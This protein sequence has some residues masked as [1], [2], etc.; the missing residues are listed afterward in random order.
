M[1]ASP[2][3]I[4]ALDMAANLAAAMEAELAGLFVE[5]EELLR[6][7]ESPQALEIAYPGEPSRTSRAIMERKLRAQSEQIR[8]TV[9]AAA[10]RAQVRWSFQTVR[11]EVASALLAAA[12]QHDIVAVGRR[13]WSF[14]HRMRIGTTALELAASSIP[15]LLISQRA[16]LGGL[17]LL[18]YYDGSPASRNALFIAATIAQTGTKKMTVL[19]AQANYEN[20]ASEIRKLLEGQDLDLRFQRVDLNDE[21]SLS[22][23]VQKQGAVLLILAGRQLLKNRETFEALLRGVEVPVLVLGDGFGRRHAQTD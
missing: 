18:V 7:A 19:L 1:D 20:R 15:L 6:V 12:G 10:D 13:G 4:A 5:E 8:S 9:A 14:G 16:P 21:K 23:A 22:R 2:H 17:R 11:G 3:S